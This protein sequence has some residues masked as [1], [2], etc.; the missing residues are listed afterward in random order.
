MDTPKVA[1]R[2]VTEGIK[3]IPGTVKEGVNKAVAQPIQES[4]VKAIWVGPDSFWKTVVFSFEVVTFMFMKIWFTVKYSTSL[5]CFL[6]F[7]VIFYNQFLIAVVLNHVMS[8]SIIQPTV[9]LRLVQ[10]QNQLEQ[11]LQ[12]ARAAQG[13]SGPFLEIGNP[14]EIGINC[15]ARAHFVHPQPETCPNRQFC[16]TAKRA[17]P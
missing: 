14:V 16:E 7:F 12:T 3:K 6:M 5:D 17:I 13:T 10:A 4:V 2:E 8:S 11:K 1:Q 9:G 15:F